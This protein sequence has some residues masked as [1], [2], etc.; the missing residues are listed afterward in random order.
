MT[1]P[2]RI[3]HRH[4]PRTGGR[5]GQ[6]IRVPPGPSTARSIIKRHFREE[7]IPLASLADRWRC[8]AAHIYSTFS[9][10]RPLAPGHIE[11]AI[12]VL[13]LD[14][15]DA[16][17]L[18]LQAAREAGWEIDINYLLSESRRACS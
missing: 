9:R 3:H 8:T 7:R 10:H 17:E 1:N 18:R 15:F 16:N 11:G 5:L 12:A 13:G 14:E 4:R 6:P 2:S